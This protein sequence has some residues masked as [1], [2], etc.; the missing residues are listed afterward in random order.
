MNGFNVVSQRFIRS[1]VT[2]PVEKCL[3]NW[4]V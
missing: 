2:G 4:L 3:L 1:T